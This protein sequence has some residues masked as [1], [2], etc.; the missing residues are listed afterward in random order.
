[1]YHNWLSRSNF[2]YNPLSCISYHFIIW[3]WNIYNT[4]ISKV[5]WCQGMFWHWMKFKKC[6]IKCKSTG[7]GFS[8]L[9]FYD[10][11]QK[12]VCMK[13]YA[14]IL[15]LLTELR[16][17]VCVLVGR[18]MDFESFA[19]YYFEFES[20]TRLLDSFIWTNGTRLFYSVN[21]EWYQ[22]YLTDK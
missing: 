15:S 17:G 8:L 5:A 11:F 18:L 12:Y 16:R 3:Y 9:L 6:K 20:P 2:L 10:L 4:Y 13:L 14:Y 1:M 22:C 21:S 7:M 19:T